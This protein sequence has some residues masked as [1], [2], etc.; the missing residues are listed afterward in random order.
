MANTQE[1]IRGLVERIGKIDKQTIEII[2]LVECKKQVE[3]E[4][5][6][7]QILQVFLKGTRLPIVLYKL[8][9]RFREKVLLFF[10]LF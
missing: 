5:K 2:V 10:V 8:S 4:K 9:E 3:G 7:Q 6:K 1:E